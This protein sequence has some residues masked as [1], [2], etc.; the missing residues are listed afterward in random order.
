M[1]KH[2]KVF[3]DKYASN[4]VSFSDAKGMSFEQPK[5]AGEIEQDLAMRDMTGFSSIERK[6]QEAIEAERKPT[7]LERKMK[8]IFG[9]AGE[10]QKLFL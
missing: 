4:A 2:D 10:F 9:A 3:E 8:R 6:K 1:S 7:L 5:K